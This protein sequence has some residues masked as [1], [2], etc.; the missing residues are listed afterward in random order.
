MF[1]CAALT[2]AQTRNTFRAGSFLPALPAVPVVDFLLRL[3]LTVA[4][5]LLQTALKLFPLTVDDVKVVVSE[6]APLLLDLAFDLL[7]VSFDSVPA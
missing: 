6:L 7:P 3:V 1:R 5:A 4:V 2:S